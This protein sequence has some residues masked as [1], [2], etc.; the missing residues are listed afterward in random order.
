MKPLFLL[1]NDDGVHAPGIAA[2]KEVASEFGEVVIAAPHVERS[3]MSHAITIHMPL[4][5]EEISENTYAI[6]GTPADCIF[7]AMSK[8][9]KRQPTY[10]LSGINRGGNLG[11]DTL[12]S[13]TVGAAME[14]RIQGVRSIA[15]SLE[16][17]TTYDFKEAQKSVRKVLE[18]VDAFSH[19]DD[20]VLNVNIPGIPH[21]DIKG[22]RASSLGRR[23]YDHDMTEGTDPRGKK[24][25]WI[26]GG[27]YMFEQ[28][29]QSDCVHLD[30]GFITLS[31]LKP[32]LY[33][34]DGHQ[35]LESWSK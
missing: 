22:F 3:A 18:R 29:E 9:L 23:I 11:T 14:G 25:F 34:Q 13:G 12:Y 32:T 15:F 10:I 28:I 27:G 35:D 6:E 30:D 26:G 7:W 1:S 17:S 5:V 33:H 19:L 21:K 4:R 24:Y 2:L 8:C 31:Y 16:T 20:A